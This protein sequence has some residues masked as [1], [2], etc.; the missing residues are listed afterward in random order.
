MVR[1]YH[2]SFSFDVIPP[3]LQRGRHALIVLRDADSKFALGAKNIYPEGIVRFVGGGLDDAEPAE[4][5]AARELEEE[6]GIRVD[7][8]KLTL[9]AEITSDITS[10]E[11]TIQ[12]T[13]FLFLYDIGNT[14]LHPADDLNGIVRF[15]REEMKQLLDRYAHLP[16]EVVDIGD[17]GNPFRWSDY[18]VYYGKIHQIALDCLE[19]NAGK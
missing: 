16:T 17:G 3:V 5:G 10:L 9:L 1:H 6:V 13:T 12:F 7:P 11:R 4:I 18:G 2:F 19:E 14:A 8:T 15:T